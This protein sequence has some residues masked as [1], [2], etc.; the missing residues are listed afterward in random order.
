MCVPD[1]V[2]ESAHVPVSRETQAVRV[3]DAVPPLFGH[4]NNKKSR[5]TSQ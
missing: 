1:V 4:N 2:D 3:L 5:F